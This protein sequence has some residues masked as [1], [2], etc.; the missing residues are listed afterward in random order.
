[1]I[2]IKQNTVNKIVTTLFEFKTGSTTT[3]LCEFINNSSQE[4]FYC[5]ATDLSNTTRYNNFCITEVS[6]S[7]AN[8]LQSQV[9]LNQEGQYTYK[10][11][12]NPNSSL[13]PTGL[14]LCEVGRLLVIGAD[15]II[16]A[17]SAD[18]ETVFYNPN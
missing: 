6:G 18:T 5:V 8:P 7:S 12:E 2:I 3:Y 13:D 16:T 14:N 1:M 4:A 9:N 11:Y 17:Y 10:I 15:E